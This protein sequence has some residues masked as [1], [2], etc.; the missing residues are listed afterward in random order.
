MAIEMVQK[1]FPGARVKWQRTP[2]VP[3]IELTV[4]ADGELLSKVPQREISDDYRGKGVDKLA[5]ALDT[6]KARR[7]L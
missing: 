2:R 6:Y 7:G 3:N 5:E 1:T 4:S